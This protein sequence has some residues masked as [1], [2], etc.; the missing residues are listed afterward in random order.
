MYEIIRKTIVVTVCN[1]LFRVRYENVEVLKKVDKCLICPNHSRI[2]DPVYL[3][4][5]VDN[6]YGMAKSE[7]FKHKFMANFLT[8]HNVFP[9]DREKTDASSLRKALKLLK[10]NDKIKLLIFP[11]GKVMKDR[12]EWGEVKNGAVYISAVSGV[13]IIPVYITPRP[14]YF[15]KVTVKFGEPIYYNKEDL[16]DKDEIEKESKKLM[17]QIYQENI[18]I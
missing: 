17:K 6:M 16:K 11:E 3:Y 14:K 12:S 9:V 13:P 15:S 2:Y 8:Y 10:T 1:I 7:L 5:K 4:P 18:A